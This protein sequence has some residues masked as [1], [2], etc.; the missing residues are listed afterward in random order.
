[1]AYVICRLCMTPL[2]AAS[3]LYPALRRDFRNI[4]TISSG[5]KQLRVTHTEIEVMWPLFPRFVCLSP[6]HRLR[7]S[8]SPERRSNEDQVPVFSMYWRIDRLEGY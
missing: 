3:P 1:M 4:E 7:S 2:F 8:S 5:Q 6:L